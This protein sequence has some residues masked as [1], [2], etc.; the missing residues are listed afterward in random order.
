MVELV[1]LYHRGT[2]PLLS[3]D[4]VGRPTSR[5]YRDRVTGIPSY[6]FVILIIHIKINGNGEHCSSSGLQSLDVFSTFVY[7]L[8]LLLHLVLHRFGTW[9]Q[10]LILH[11]ESASHSEPAS[12]FDFTIREWVDEVISS[13]Q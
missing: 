1:E 11:F 12:Y 2:G 13:R 5:S 8:V 3:D 9:R 10:S 4:G 6:I 7:P